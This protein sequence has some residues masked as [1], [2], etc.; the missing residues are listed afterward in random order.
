MKDRELIEESYAK[1]LMSA[2]YLAAF[3]TGNPMES[4]GPITACQDELAVSHARLFS[5][6]AM[7]LLKE[8][9][10]VT[11][12]SHVTIK[13]DFG[14]K[15]SRS[16]NEVYAGLGEE[17]IFLRDMLSSELFFQLIEGKE[18]A[19]P[20]EE[21]RKLVKQ[22][23]TPMAIVCI[24]GRLEFGFRLSHFIE[25]FQAE[26]LNPIIE[27]CEKEGLN[28]GEAGEFEEDGALG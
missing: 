13:M 14:P 6:N 8:T 21:K 5:Q 18:D 23:F 2:A 15:P 16:F 20:E 4:A 17:V 7:R 27:Q 25:T 28:L 24:N 9:G 22:V 3:A 1:L 11:R 19:I 26:I 10:D 12:F